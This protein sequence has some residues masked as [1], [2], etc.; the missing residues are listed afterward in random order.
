M[1]C[2]ILIFTAIIWSALPRSDAYSQTSELEQHLRDEYQ[3]KTLVLR[4]FYS[5]DSL[6]YN[7]SGWPAS[8]NGGDWTTDGFVQVEG[9]G[10]SSDRLTIKARRIVVSWLDKK[11]FEL[12]PLGHSKDK[13]KKGVRVV[14]NVDP[15]MHD[16]SPEQ[17]DASLSKIFLTGQDSLADIVPDY[18]KSC[19][20]GGLKGTDKDCAFAPELLA[21]PGVVA[22]S[23][24]NSASNLPSR[25][26]DGLAGGV[27][28]VSK[29]VSP[30]KA[31]YTPEP[32]IPAAARAAKYEGTVVLTLVVNKEGLPTDIRISQPLGYGL[33]AKAVEAVQRWRFS[34]AQK[35]GQPVQVKIAIEINFRQY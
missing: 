16:P 29:S 25:D 6:L 23:S 7:S 15:G 21:I 1:L 17:V 8:A 33:D 26:H 19:V 34:P 22:S 14:I 31:N 2:R 13:E 27:F 11:Q 9:I 32:A 5:G 18:W 3:G 30:P 24:E 12:R 35:D 10:W 28:L 20:N 4:G